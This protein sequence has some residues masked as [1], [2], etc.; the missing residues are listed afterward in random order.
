MPARMI[1]SFFRAIS[2]HA[3][4]LNAS[5]RIQYD[6]RHVTEMLALA[7]APA[8]PLAGLE[9]REKRRETNDLGCGRLDAPLRMRAIPERCCRKSKI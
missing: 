6:G 5:A 3:A 7:R 2:G 1:S 9:E 8:C 4:P